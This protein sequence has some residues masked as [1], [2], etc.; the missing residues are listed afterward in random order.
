[1]SVKYIYHI[2]AFFLLLVSPACHA[3]DTV[4]VSSD[5]A[6]HAFDFVPRIPEREQIESYLDEKDFQYGKEY[7]PAAGEGFFKRLWR[8]V[9]DFIAQIFHA[10][11]YLPLILRILFVVACLV[12]LFIIATKT[13]LYRLFYEDRETKNPEFS[14]V[15]PLHEEYNFDEAVSREVMQGNYRNAIRLL[16]LKLLKELD[17]MEII[18]ISRDKTNRDY[19]LEIGDANIRKEFA[20][21]TRIYNH[22]W[23][24]KYPLTGIDYESLAPQFLRFTQMLHAG[25]E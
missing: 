18:R 17:S 22:I 20:G 19:S 8:S 10:V 6:V 21:L 3:G 4:A 24:G 1:M 13:K 5:T 14:M 7:K 11:I 15:D 9:L 23:Y 12:V 25:Y 2:I 16:H